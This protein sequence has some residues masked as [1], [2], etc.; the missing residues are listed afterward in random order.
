[1]SPVIHGSKLFFRKSMIME[2]SWNHCQ[3]ALAAHFGPSD[4]ER[5]T[6][7]V[8]KSKEILQEQYNSSVKW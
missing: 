4:T 2:A 6:G 1:M 7:F 3:K 5:V 8:V